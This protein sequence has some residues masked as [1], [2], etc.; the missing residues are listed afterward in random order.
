MSTL[1][2]T[3]RQ[4]RLSG[5]SAN[6][7]VRVQEAQANRLSHLE[8]LELI[9]QDELNVRQGRKIERRKITARFNALKT[10]EDFDWDFNS[11]L[12]KKELFELATCRF[13]E[14]KSDVL[15]LGPPGLGKT[16]LAQAIGYEAIKRNILV[17]Y[18]SIFD[19]ARDLL[20]EDALK[21]KAKI[22]KHYINVDLLIIDDMGLKELPRHAG[23]Y[24]LEIIMRRH[25]NKS[26]LITSNRPLEDWGKL[27]GDVPTAAAILD[28]FLHHSKIITFSG[29]S[30]RLRNTNILKPSK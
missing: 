30:F 8:F 6:L 14:E 4:L 23:E 19:L 9:L 7:S 17:R 15:F 24:F 12:Q 20:Q 10:L 2:S 13:I 29:R 25:E 1:E 27:V 22:L 5:L 21:Q 11:S 18:T 16:H 3:F 26:T 28:R